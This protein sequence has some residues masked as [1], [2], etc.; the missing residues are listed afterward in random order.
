MDITQQI[1]QVL[2]TQEKLELAGLGSLSLVKKHAELDVQNDKILPPKKELVFNL[3]R[4]QKAR[5]AFN[6]LSSQILKD[7]LEKGIYEISGVGKWTNFAGK[8]DFVANPQV[9]GDDF[10]GFE[11]IIV[12]RVGAGSPQ[13]MQVA[14]EDYKYNKSILWAF[15]VLMPVAGILYFAATQKEKIFGKASFESLELSKIEKKSA[16]PAVIDST[17]MHPKDSIK[18]DSL[19]YL[20][21]NKSK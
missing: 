6:D 20:P 2:N 16:K 11:E 10:Y 15:L 1:L 18:K 7:L 8:I 19:N 4:G 14:E 12:P 3:D 17:N 13:L 5:N 21:N 9:A